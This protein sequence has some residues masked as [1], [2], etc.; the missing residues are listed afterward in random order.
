MGVTYKLKDEVVNFIVEQKRVNPSLS[1]RGLVQIVQEKFQIHVSKSSVNQIFK[2]FQL[3]SPVGRRTKKERKLK[4]FKIPNPPLLLTQQEEL[5]VIIPPQEEPPAVVPPWEEPAVIIPP[6]E[7]PPVIAPQVEKEP[8]PIEVKVE[9]S[10][11][12]FSLKVNFTPS[13]PL[14]D[15]MGCFFLKA[16]E[17]QVSASSI[18]G[19]VLGKHTSAFLGADISN[20][21]ET[22]LYLHAFGIKRLEEINQYQG[23]GLWEINNLKHKIDTAL[24]RKAVDSVQ[25]LKSFSIGISNEYGQAFSEIS[26]IKITL[27]DMTELF[28]DAQLK[29]LWISHSVHCV[30]NNPLNKIL[31]YLSTNLI[32]N[33]EPLVMMSVPGYKNIG[34][35]FYDFLLAFENVSGKTISKIAILDSFAEEI[36]SFS[37]IPSKKRSFV[38]GTWPWQEEFKQFLREDIKGTQNFY[39][40]PLEKTIF[41]SDFK[42]QFAHSP[43]TGRIKLRVHLLRESADSEPFLGIL[44]NIPDDVMT[45]EEVILTYLKHWPNVKE[46]YDGLMALTEKIP[47]G[48]ADLVPPANKVPLLEGTGFYQISS[49]NLNVWQSIQFL[50]SALN[51]YGQRHFF[52]FS[53]RRHNFEAM[54]EH[55]FNLP[56]RIKRDQNS[57]EVTLTI[58]L[59]YSHHDE[60][61]FAVR[62]LNESDIRGP[63]G[64][65]LTLKIQ[66]S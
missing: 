7:E 65:K 20:V 31:K 29:T 18:L 43:Q 62:R 52:P 35:Q 34:K 64:V 11:V 36:A 42:T 16:A 10:P 40:A 50:L 30:L 49:G 22:L 1:C 56:G 28:V 4:K 55:F 51:Q 27:S 61:V 60:L 37:V 41:Y 57:W 17:R 25:S 15:G 47:Y 19:G 58:P 13:E 44:A 8:E 46:G 6:Q 63:G 45:S 26:Y 32:S 23:Q 21:S 39:C 9:P 14:I 33:L 24:L 54:R 3:S 48:T 66:A 2:S 38:V 59:N 5:P 53:C 12:P